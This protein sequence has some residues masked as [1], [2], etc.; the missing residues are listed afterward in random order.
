MNEFAYYQPAPLFAQPAAP[1]K[2]K[3]NKVD[4]DLAAQEA[5]GR[6]RQQVIDA[7]KQQQFRP[8]AGQPVLPLFSNGGI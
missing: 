2:K 6:M 7:A 3:R 5:L 8:G 1:A 4:E